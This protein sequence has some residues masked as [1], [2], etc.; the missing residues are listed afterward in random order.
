MATRKT[1]AKP[2][3]KNG[4]APKKPTANKSR[5][6]NKISAKER[7]KSVE[8][9]AYYIAEHNQFQGNPADF[10]YAAEAQMTNQSMPH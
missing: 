6:S 8:V 7:Y 2:S 10:W 3:M 1:T 5:K 9:A 4:I